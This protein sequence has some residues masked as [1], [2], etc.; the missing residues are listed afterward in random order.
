M[1]NRTMLACAVAAAFCASPVSAEEADELAIIERI[2]IIGNHEDT[3]KATGSAYVIS[4]QELQK[5]EY[6]NVHSILRSVPGVYLREEDG[7]GFY[8]RIGIRASS[9][10]RSDRISIMEDGVPAAMAP[11]ANTSAYFFPNVGRMR[12]VEVLKGPETLLYGPQTT[13]GT[14][15]LLSTAIPETPRGFLNA[16]I[17]DFSS[18]KI[19]AN[20]GATHGQWGYLLETYQRVTDGHQEIDRS[21]I[22]AGI[23]TEEYLGKLRWKSDENA[24]FRQQLDIK[25]QYAQEYA[26]VSYLGLTDA[27]FKANPN[28]RYGLSELERMDR[29]RKGFSVQHQIAFTADTLL[30]T[31]Y[32]DYETKRIYNRLNQINGINID[33]N[34]I[35]RQINNNAANV[36]LLQGILDGT[37]DTTHANGV[38]YGHNHQA[39][40]SRGLQL[41]LLHHFT[42]GS[43]AHELTVAARRHEDTTHNAVNG[44]GNSIYDQINGSLVYRST[45]DATPQRG[46]ADATAIW[47]ADRISIGDWTLIPVVRFEDIDSKA[48]LVIDADADQAAARNTNSI[49]KTTAGLGVN[50]TI[51]DN[52]TALAGIHQ[53]FAPPGNAARSGE[54]GEESTNYEAGVRFRSGNLG[55]DAIAFFTDYDNALRNCLVAN[56]CAG[57]VVEGTE[58]AGQKEVYGLELGL[59]TELY[60]ADGFKVPLRFAYTWTDGEYTKNSDT[61]NGIQKGDVLD[62]TPKHIASLQLGL[63]GSE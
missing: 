60:Q 44:I 46:S 16:E 2:T 24:R 8:P 62:Y 49:N 57:N 34:G 5:F 26:N 33:A 55:I 41:E 31:T 50:Y 53:G 56:P 36:A 19:H 43:V 13:S 25:Y 39:F 20:Y 58:Q 7:N 15:N 35:T 23:D 10:G 54:K 40:D 22:D 29:G 61:A 9:S 17:G 1:F 42:T 48:N 37:A 6:T 21:N 32:Y 27:D 63:E 18:R 59:F 14:I 12:A 4:E 28:R 30:T 11:Y 47:I 51:N 38:R 45:S 3:T 52:W